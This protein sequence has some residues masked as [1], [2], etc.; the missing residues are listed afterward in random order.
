MN[1]RKIYIKN[2]VSHRCKML[3]E[4]S[5]EKLGLQAASIILGVVDIPNGISLLQRQKLDMML[6][7]S[8]LELLED[9]NMI[10]V[11]RIKSIIV[12]MINYYDDVPEGINFSDYISEKISCDYA[13]LAREFSKVMGITIQQFIINS[14][15]KRAKEML[16]YDR[17]SLTQISYK[18]RY[19]SVAH[20]SNQFKKTTG[21][22]PSFFRE[23][24]AIRAKNQNNIGIMQYSDNII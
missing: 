5:L 9:R 11:E 3:V 1:N 22:S 12:E 13:Y 17:L 8:G 23:M 24:E 10:L 16:L 20:L 6:A 7:G 14:K 4:S 21:H 18:L 15:I 19:S 2:M